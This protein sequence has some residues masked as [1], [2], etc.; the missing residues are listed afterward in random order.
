MSDSKGNVKI[1][2][3][4]T[5][6]RNLQS[7]NTKVEIM[8]SSKT[9]SKVNMKQNLPKSVPK[10][11]T[12]KS[13][14]KA[15]S[16]KN[17]PK[18]PRQMNAPKNNI[19]NTAQDKNDNLNS[20]LRDRD[21]V[22]VQNTPAKV[23]PKTN[24]N[25]KEYRD[26]V[27]R[28]NRNNVDN[29]IVSKNKNNNEHSNT[30]IRTETSVGDEYPLEKQI[31]KGSFGY[32]YM[33]RNPKTGELFACKAEKISTS[34]KDRL[35]A[36]YNLYK[37][38]RKNKVRCVP[39]VDTYLVTSDWNLMMMQLLGKSLDGIFV[40]NKNQLDLGT[41][42]KI[43]IMMIDGLEEIHKT[44]VIHRDIKPNNFMFG[45]REEGED[46]KLYIVDFGLSKAWRDPNTG[47]HISQKQGRSM[48]GTA[49]YA[50]I[51]IHL[52][53]EPSRRDDLESVGYV[54]VY[55]AKGVLP[56]QGLAK[57]KKE[58]AIDEI[59]DKKMST[60]TDELCSGLPVCF[61]E[62]INYAKGLSFQ[63]EPNYNM[64]RKMI[65]NSSKKDDIDLVL[66][67]EDED[68]YKDKE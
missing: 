11:S 56:W 47:S 68:Y 16:V 19:V 36:E 67:W 45:R 58:S 33:G 7:T 27:T 28:N 39:R 53:M 62:L 20:N 35:R 25:Q 9:N 26:V 2:T 60:T 31:G 49:R 18:T 12:P 50:S 34:N 1:V 41:V 54:L 61:K 63:E 57:R 64:M 10:S 24:Q 48:I 65:M 55:L 15:G 14:P 66:A 46:T 59:K 17:I 40:D 3:A 5:P 32:V 38:F 13:V 44:G 52:G 30:R 6:K 51:N 43:G 4:A 8:K 22:Q 29:M 37:I 23:Q 21:I 42:M